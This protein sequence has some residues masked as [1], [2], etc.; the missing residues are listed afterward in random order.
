MKL[1]FDTE[2]RDI[3]IIFLPQQVTIIDVQNGANKPNQK[4][5]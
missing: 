1:R 2:Y 5:L 4:W 3:F